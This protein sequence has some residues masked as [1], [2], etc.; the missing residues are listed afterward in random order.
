MDIILVQ[1][2]VWVRAQVQA[3]TPPGSQQHC[4]AW[5]NKWVDGR[6]K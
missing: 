5:G 4:A 3:R 1:V 2:Q 6:Y